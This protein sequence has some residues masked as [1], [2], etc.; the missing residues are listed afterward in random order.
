MSPKKTTGDDPGSRLMTLTEV[1]HELRLTRSAIYPKIYSGEL[2]AVAVGRNERGLRVLRSS[3]E[4]Y[5][6]RIELEGQRRFGGVA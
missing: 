4:E 6:Q 1:A 3:F 5:Q 2:A